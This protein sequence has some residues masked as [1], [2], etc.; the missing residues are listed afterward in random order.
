MNFTN[1]DTQKVKE[2]GSEIIKLSTEY[3]VKITE[4][5]KKLSTFPY[6]TEEWSG[7]PAEKYSEQVSQDKVLYTDFG[8]N[9]KKLGSEIIKSG[10]SIEN[11]CDVTLA[12]GDYKG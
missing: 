2:I 9:I 5:F 10:E 3:N 12:R 6:D 11:C 1:A 7:K 8:D 4:L